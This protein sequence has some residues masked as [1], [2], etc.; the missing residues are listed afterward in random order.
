MSGPEAPLESGVVAAE[1]MMHV[2]LAEDDGAL[3]AASVGYSFHC[4]LL[5]NADVPLVQSTLGG[6]ELVSEN[7]LLVRHGTFLPLLIACGDLGVLPLLV[8]CGDL[9]VLPLLEACG[10]LRVFPLLVACG[11]LNVLCL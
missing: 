7:L 1:G 6:L 10:D 2:V 4:L 5:L 3:S 8:A 11:D 9:S